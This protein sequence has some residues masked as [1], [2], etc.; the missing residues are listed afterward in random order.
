MPAP[1]VDLA[2]QIARG[3]RLVERNRCLECHT[4]DGQAN[5]APTLA[6]LFGTV[7][8]FEGG[9]TTIADEDYLRES[10]ESPDEKIVVGFATGAMPKVFFSAPELSALVEYIKSLQ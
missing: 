9:G 3:K 4:T 5:F 1:T 8:G 6:G 10:I 2:Q 7:R